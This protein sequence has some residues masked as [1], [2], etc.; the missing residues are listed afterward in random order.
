MLTIGRAAIPKPTERKLR[1][2]ASLSDDFMAF[3]RQEL[4]GFRRPVAAAYA[5]TTPVACAVALLG[6]GWIRLAETAGALTVFAALALAL[7]GR[8]ELPRIEEDF[9]RLTC[10]K[11]RAEADLRCGYG[12]DIFL[13]IARPPRFF[14]SAVGVLV[15]VD[16]GDFKTL[17]MSVEKG[18]EDPRWPI[19]CKGGLRRRIWRWCRL[20]ASHDLIRFATEGTRLEPFHKPKYIKSIEVFEA[21]H[22]ALGEPEDGAVVH[23]PFEEVIDTVTRLL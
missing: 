2:A 7:V 15:F 5:L 4:I 9:D 22:L 14:E 16:I 17:F 3:A 6:G 21:I 8:R 20:P 23:I 12:E 18:A 11:R 19:Y 13:R 10:L 1:S